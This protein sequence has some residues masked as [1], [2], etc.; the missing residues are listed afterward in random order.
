M[1][2]V[3]GVIGDVAI[4]VCTG[5]ARAGKLVA[6]VFVVLYG[7]GNSRSSS[8]VWYSSSSSS[9]KAV[10]VVIVVVVVVVVVGVGVGVT[11]EE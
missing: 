2:V 6:V 10:A 9:S 3:V 1:V 7:I 11:V 4:V 5:A 8:M